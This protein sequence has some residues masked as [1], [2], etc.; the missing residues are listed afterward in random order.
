M[1]LALRGV[2][3]A[4]GRRLRAAQGVAYTQAQLVGHA[5]HQPRK[6]PQFDKVFPDPTR[7]RRKKSDR[8]IFAS[9]Q[10]W[11]SHLS[12]VFRSA[13]THDGAAQ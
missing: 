6:M 10:A 13:G 12:Q 4:E 2:T 11:T 8:E 1:E 7:G 5:F 3:D 9:M